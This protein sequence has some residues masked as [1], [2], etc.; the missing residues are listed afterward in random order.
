MLTQKPIKICFIKGN[1][2]EEKFFELLTQQFNKHNISLTNLQKEQFFNYYKLLVSWNEKFNLTTITE[3][4]D[5]IIKHFLDSVVCEKFLK[6]NAKIIDIGAGA[7]FPSL[8][9]KIVRPD[10]T[11]VLVDS[12]NKK[13]LFLQEVVSKLALNNVTTLHFRA[14]DL[15]AKPEY[16]E[17]FDYCVSRAVAQLN[18]LCEYC[19]PFVKVGG[20]M[21]A[22]KSS[23]ITQE[24]NETRNAIKLLGGK[25]SEV[26]EITINDVVRK[27]VK[28][29][30]V[31]KC[32]SKYPRGKNKPR[33]MPL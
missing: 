4:N 21:I 26:S 29:D 19:L 2:M 20:Q 30:K 16:R 25:L 18:T 13:V 23:D 1:I 17:G 22:Y 33:L 3:E 31:L 10:L 12:V 28:I 7:G 5:V 14:E 9:L 6:P 8:P 15:A 24:L 27:F 32:P 11:V